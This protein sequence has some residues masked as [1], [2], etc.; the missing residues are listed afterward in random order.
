MEVFGGGAVVVRGPEDEGRHPVE[1][2]PNWQ[3]SVVLVW[4]DLGNQVGGFFR[5]GHEPNDASGPAT[6]LWSNIWFRH[7]PG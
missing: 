5:I 6:S 2:H 4:W 7:H 3:E 1:D